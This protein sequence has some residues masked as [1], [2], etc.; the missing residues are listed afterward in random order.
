[1]GYLLP[2]RKLYKY[3]KIQQEMDVLQVMD[4]VKPCR[5]SGIAYIAIVFVHLFYNLSNEMIC[6]F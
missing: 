5:C 1:M 3:P 4:L 6:L 2:W